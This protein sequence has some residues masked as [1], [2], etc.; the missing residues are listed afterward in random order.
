MTES[1]ANK[2]I[3]VIGG[4]LRQCCLANLLA[5]DGN[6]VFALCMSECTELDMAVTATDELT[7]VLPQ[8]DVVIFPLPMESG[9]GLLNAP[10]CPKPPMLSECLQAISP[11]A[12]VFGG[13]V[14]ES[15]RRTAETFGVAVH[16]YYEREELIVRNC[17]PTAEG[18][19]AIAMQETARTIFESR[20]LV[21]GHGRVGKVVARLLGA[22]GARV[23]VAARR[24]EDLAWIKTEGYTPVPITELSDAA[25]KADLIFNTVPV[26]LFDKTLLA[27]VR[28]DALIIDLASKPGGVDFETAKSLGLRV[29]WAL[30]LPGK[31]APMTAAEIIRD[32]VIHMITEEN[33]IFESG[34]KE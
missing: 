15:I 32:T 26:Q 1:S 18:A 13:K 30:S 6:R 2:T 10:F 24:Q 3:A 16:D 20:C 21:V 7:G 25:E 34:S 9:K 27:H 28:P 17:V 23:S 8:C 22:C 33:R 12:E 19:L 29:I 4:D 31:V 5:S 11:F 14:N